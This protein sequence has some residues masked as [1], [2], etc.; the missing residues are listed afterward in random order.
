MITLNI[1][2]FVL[3]VSGDGAWSRF[4]TD[5][6]DTLETGFPTVEIKVLA[7]MMESL[8]ASCG[9]EAGFAIQ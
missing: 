3:P 1:P 2:V 6:A 5:M 9:F 4:Q 8:A 7:S